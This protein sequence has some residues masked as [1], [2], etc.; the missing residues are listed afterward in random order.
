ML[1]P[2]RVA[3]RAATR[4][5]LDND[6]WISTYSIGS[7]GY[8]QIGWKSK[9]DRGMTTAHRAAWVH[10]WGQI[11][12]GM[13]VDHTCHR[14]RCVNPKHLRLLTNADNARRNGL[15]RDYPV[16]QSCIRNHPAERRARRKNGS[17]YCLDC[18]A[19][20]QARHRQRTAR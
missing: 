20:A 8:A 13:T 1:I 10:Y 2:A 15:G 6:C 12:P 7:H 19:L 4:Y 11:P 16:G 17:T 18:N 14:V 3:E 5:N 9:S